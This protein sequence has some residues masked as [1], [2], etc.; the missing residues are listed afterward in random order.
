MLL[1][2]LPVPKVAL[3]FLVFSPPG[4]CSTVPCIPCHLPIPQITLCPLLTIILSSAMKVSAW[5]YWWRKS[6]PID[7]INWWYACPHGKFIEDTQAAHMAM[8]CCTMCSRV[9]IAK[10]IAHTL[11][12]WRV[13]RQPS[14]PAATGSCAGVMPTAP[15]V[16]AA[17]RLPPAPSLERA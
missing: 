8:K 17:E 4:C 6:C 10:G 14:W 13:C 5:P 16:V 11:S 1:A 2:A 12:S 9:F 7:C 15:P 3:P